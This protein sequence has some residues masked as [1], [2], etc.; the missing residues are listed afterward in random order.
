[1]RDLLRG[2]FALPRREPIA[3]LD[4]WWRRH[5][6]FGLAAEGRPQIDRAIIGGYTADRVGYA[7][8]SGYAAALRCLVPDLPSGE[9][10]ALC[11]TEEGGGH[12][13]AIHTALRLDAD[14]GGHI[15]GRK[16][17]ATLGP[18]ARRLLVAVSLGQRDDGRNRIRLVSVD[19]AAPGVTLT[20]MPETPF[21]PEIPHAEVTFEDVAVAAGDLLPG[22]GYERYIKPFRTI[23]DL[24]V[25]GA[26]CAWLLGVARGA[27]W[28]REI[29]EPLC[30]LLAGIRA[31]ALD[32][33]LAPE[34]HL[35]LGGLLRLAARLIEESAPHWTLVDGETRRR[36]ERDRTLLGIAGRAR[37]ERLEAA[38]RA[39]DR[40]GSPRR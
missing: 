39:I 32:D 9:P 4:D 1:M 15:T 29:Q 25:H 38:W 6:A 33:P 37:A 11:I 12:P 17:W 22:D 34:V 3:D 7:F 40:E 10:A 26:L 16:R 23:E 31:L 19:A 8:A 14:G 13:R 36:W 35:A 18:R 20:T 24:H 5:L 2:L 28:P 27:G 21:A 30:G